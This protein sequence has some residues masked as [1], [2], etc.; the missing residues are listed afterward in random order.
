MPLSCTATLATKPLSYLSLDPGP[1]ALTPPHDVET[2]E[3]GP[4]PHEE[5]LIIEVEPVPPQ[6]AATNTFALT[7]VPRNSLLQR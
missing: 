1:N 6:V 5:H 2:R 4:S 7:I 3:L